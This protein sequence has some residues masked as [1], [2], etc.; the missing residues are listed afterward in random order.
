MLKVALIH[1]PELQTVYTAGKTCVGAQ[2]CI[3]NEK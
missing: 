3:S 2:G 1:L